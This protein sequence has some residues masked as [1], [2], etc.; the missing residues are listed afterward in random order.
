[1][2]LVLPIAEEDTDIQER[3]HNGGWGIGDGWTKSECCRESKRG[4]E[5]ERDGTIALHSSLIEFA[6]CSLARLSLGNGLGVCVCV[7]VCVYVC[8]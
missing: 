4:R 2:I 3:D 8:V 1:M 7:C 6:S 5:Q